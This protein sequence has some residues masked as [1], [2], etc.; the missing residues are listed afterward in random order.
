MIISI[1]LC[2]QISI[3]KN[4]NRPPLALSQTSLWRQTIQ[5]FVNFVVILSHKIIN[6]KKTTVFQA[7]IK[8]ILTFKVV[9]NFEKVRL[10]PMSN[11]PIY[12]YGSIKPHKESNS[13]RL[14]CSTVSSKKL[15]L[16]P[17]FPSVSKYYS[18]K[19]SYQVVEKL[20]L[21]V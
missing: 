18:I 3:I 21:Q 12:V 16:F 8:N 13:I 17:L 9:N 5:I 7:E 2:N 6:E 14:V 20:K 10:T 4:H 15:E 19:N 1:I 11:A